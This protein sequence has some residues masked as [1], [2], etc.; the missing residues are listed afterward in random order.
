MKNW[1]EDIGAFIG[2]IGFLR[3]FAFLLRGVLIGVLICMLLI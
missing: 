1:I 3:R 2:L